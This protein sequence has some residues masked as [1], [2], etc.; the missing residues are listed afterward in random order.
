MCGLYGATKLANR[1]VFA[2]DLGGTKVAAAAV[3]RHGKIMARAVE[4]V[5]RSSKFAAIAQIKRLAQQ[6]AKPARPSEAFLAGGLAFP[7]LVRR[8]GTVW[9]PNLPGWEHVPLRTRLQRSMGIPIAIESDR[10]AAAI[11]ET[12]FGAAKGKQD[13]VLLII[14]TGIGAGIISGG[15]LVRG[16]HELS[17]CAGWMVVTD[18]YPNEARRIGQLETFTAGPAVARAAAERLKEGVTGALS[19]LNP[20][21]I[22]GRLVAEAARAGDPAAQRIFDHLGKIL[23]RGI[24]NII[25]L[26]DPEVVIIGGGMADSADL[27]LPSVVSTVRQFAQPIS[28]RQTKIRVSRLRGDANLLGAARLAW[29][30]VPRHGETSAEPTAVQPAE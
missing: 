14:G 27:F 29:G 25:S 19:E 12:W 16:A 9:A 13:A 1:L 5:D 15:R 4:L 21:D 24:A 7:G 11:G 2:A 22:N 18:A 3:T 20:A 26:F 30:L 17:G 6:L 28:A 8:S 10:N 23:G